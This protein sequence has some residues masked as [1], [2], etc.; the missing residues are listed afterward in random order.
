MSL[1]GVY[2]NNSALARRFRS[3]VD[4]EPCKTPMAF[5]TWY[6]GEIYKESITSHQLRKTN[7]MSPVSIQQPEIGIAVFPESNFQ[8]K[9]KIASVGGDS[10]FSPLF[11][12]PTALAHQP[13]WHRQSHGQHA[14]QSIPYGYYPHSPFNYR[15]CSFLYPVVFISLCLP[16]LSPTFWTSEA[17]NMN[18]L[19]VYNTYFMSIIATAG[20]ML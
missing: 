17:S 5:T 13:S 12:S 9:I 7:Y 8:P 20:S 19:M 3:E 4:L 16:P 11:H 14:V 10:T 1:P 2:S 18:L 6:R 15:P